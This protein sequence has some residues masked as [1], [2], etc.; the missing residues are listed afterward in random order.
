MKYKLEIAFETP[1]ALARAVSLLQPQT[2]PPLS[3]SSPTTAP[4][5]IGPTSTVVSNALATVLSTPPPPTRYVVPAPVSPF[6]PPSLPPSSP[7]PSLPAGPQ[8]SL[9]S[10]SLSVVP[11]PPHAGL[12]SVESDKTQ[13]STPSG[14]LDAFGAPWS[15]DVHTKKPTKDKSGRYKF[16]RGLDKAVKADWLAKYPDT[17]TPAAAP[18]G[19]PTPPPGTVNPAS[20]VLSPGGRNYASVVQAFGLASNPKAPDSKTP[21]ELVALLAKW[22]IDAKGLES[23]PGE[24]DTAHRVLTELA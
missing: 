2:P 19:V 8:A 11:P 4:A 18:A 17:S 3:P 16:G 12:L 22:G 15:A 24:W 14:D 6:A 5:S 21:V 13:A 9:G 20:Q 1:E 7:A 10:P 23:R